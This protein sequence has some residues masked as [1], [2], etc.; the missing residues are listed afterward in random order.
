MYIENTKEKLTT[1]STCVLVSA[2]VLLTIVS[3]GT[4]L[5]ICLGWSIFPAWFNVNMYI[6]FITYVCLCTYDK[7]FI[8]Y[9]CV[10]TTNMCQSDSM[11][12]NL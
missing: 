7:L 5:C 8:T 4:G 9:V 2:N 1:C 11:F 12:I 6:V 10:H 3:Q